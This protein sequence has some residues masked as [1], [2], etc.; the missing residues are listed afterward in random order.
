MIGNTHYKCLGRAL[1]LGH[2]RS[3]DCPTYAECKQRVVEMKNPI[4]GL[5]VRQEVQP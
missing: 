2:C 3:T 5:P 4:T 1:D